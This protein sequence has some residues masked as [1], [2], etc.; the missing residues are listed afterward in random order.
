MPGDQGVR[1]GVPP[2][3]WATSLI[4]LTDDHGITVNPATLS[5]G[6]EYFLT[7]VIGNRGNASGGRYLSHPNS[8]DV[9]AAV[10]VWNTTLSRVCSCRPCRTS[11]SAATNGIYEQYFLRSGAYDV[12]G[13]RMNI[14]TV[15]DGIVA[16][17]NAILAGDPNALGGKTAE[18]W[19]KISRRICARKSSSANT[20]P[21]SPTMASHPTRTGVSHRRT[22]RPST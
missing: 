18:Q 14:Q 10:M 17:L 13:F 2:N 4:F 5:G 7:A 1:P 22:S 6:S 9:A 16:A 12:V 19:S 20:A 11:T 15:F 8:I 21:H 3:F